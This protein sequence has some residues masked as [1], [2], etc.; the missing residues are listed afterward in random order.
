M[1]GDTTHLNDL[2]T[3]SSSVRSYARSNHN[4][5]QA[6]ARLVVRMSTKY[7]IPHVSLMKPSISSTVNS[8]GGLKPPKTGSIMNTAPNTIRM[9]P[10]TRGVSSG[11]P[12]ILFAN[13]AF[14]TT[15]SKNNVA[16]SDRGP[17]AIWRQ[18]RLWHVQKVQKVQKVRGKGSALDAVAAS[19]PFAPK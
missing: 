6:R 14:H 17:T 8:A 16:K 11:S 5:K 3:F 7:V 4:T 13:M 10:T 15:S 18:R 19:I 9:Q 12:S 2:S 1:W